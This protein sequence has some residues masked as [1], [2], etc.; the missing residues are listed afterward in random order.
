MGLEQVGKTDSV[1]RFR[2]FRQHE[3]H[4]SARSEVAWRQMHIPGADSPYHEII[5]QD[6]RLDSC[7]A[8]SEQAR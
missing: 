4:L 8:R 6:I 1:A 5:T 2:L 3:I 7:K